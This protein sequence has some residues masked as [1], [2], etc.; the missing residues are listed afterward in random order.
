M[1]A[2]FLPT[3]FAVFFL[4]IS[5]PIFTERKIQGAPHVQSSFT[6]RVLNRRYISR[7]LHEHRRGIN[8]ITV[9]ATH[10]PNYWAYR[11]RSHPLR[12]PC[13]RAADCLREMKKLDV[14]LRQGRNLGLILSGS[15]IKRLVYYSS[16]K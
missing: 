7:I 9:L 13:G 4:S 5:V 11:S 12:Y 14:H 16:G 2:R 8:Y 1:K 6:H 10:G 15:R 3:L